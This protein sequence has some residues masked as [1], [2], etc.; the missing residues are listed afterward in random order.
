MPGAAKH[1]TGR[2]TWRVDHAPDLWS[3]GLLPEQP[4]SFQPGQ[5]ATLGVSNGGRPIE[6]PYSIVSSPKEKELEF[7]FE[8][9]PEGGL[10]PQ[11]HKLKTGDEL[12]IRPACKGLFQLNRKDGRRK[13]FMVSTVTGVAPSVSM[14]RALAAAP[15]PEHELIV[16][17]AASRSFELGY[18]RELESLARQ[19]SWIRYIPTVS[20]PWEDQGWGGEKG[21][22]E[23]LIR[24]YTELLGLTPEN[25]IAY[26]CGHPGMV[27]N[28][29][30]ILQRAG[31][32]EE[33]IH[34]EV[35]WV[36]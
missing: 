22:A 24:K 6:R 12:L 23:D 19:H 35:Y 25:T 2:I 20:R 28:S 7:F 11:L 14:L 13:H 3:I 30:G 8:L 31:W 32:S 16:L 33:S 36:V 29:G 1:L 9:V 17:Q 26:L 21:R 5:Y 27:E 34:K 18:A 10:T 15:E 4:L